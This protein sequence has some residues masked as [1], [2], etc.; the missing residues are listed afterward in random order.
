[1][2]NT[3]HRKLDE[4]FSKFNTA[5]AELYGDL[6]ELSTSENYRKLIIFAFNETLNDT[7][8]FYKLI[9]SLLFRQK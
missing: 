1:M 4:I 7:S 2:N 6:I 3:S 9:S 8:H 5:L